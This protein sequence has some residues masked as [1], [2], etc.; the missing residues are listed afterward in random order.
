M[1][2][3]PPSTAGSARA[4]NITKLHNFNNNKWNKIIKAKFHNFNNKKWNKIIK[5]KLHNF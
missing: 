4:E 1:H 5:A 2:G 3:P